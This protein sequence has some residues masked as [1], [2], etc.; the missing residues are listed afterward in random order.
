MK[1]PFGFGKGCVGRMLLKQPTS[2][3]QAWLAKYPK[4]QIQCGYDVIHWSLHKQW[5][6]SILSR[7]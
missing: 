6:E 1:I 2:E 3:L 5:I 7:R 4:P